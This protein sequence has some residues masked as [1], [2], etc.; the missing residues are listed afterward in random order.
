M[1]RKNPS[2]Q[3]AERRKKTAKR[4]KVPH[5]Q[6]PRKLITGGMKTRRRLLARGGKPGVKVTRRGLSAYHEIENVE[7]MLKRLK[8]QSKP[9]HAGKPGK[10]TTSGRR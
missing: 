7:G 3:E 8:N 6:V 2:R 1:G 4:L 10:G 9:E 5:S